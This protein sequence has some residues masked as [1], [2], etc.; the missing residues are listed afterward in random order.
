MLSAA[1]WLQ[2]R[3]KTAGLKV[4]VCIF[5]ALHHPSAICHHASSDVVDAHLILNEASGMT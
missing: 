3:L 1:E 5:L 2:S 4:P